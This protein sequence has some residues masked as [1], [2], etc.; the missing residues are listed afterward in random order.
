MLKRQDRLET[1]RLKNNKYK[2]DIETLIYDMKTR[3]QEDEE[4][5]AVTTATER[6]NIL[7]AFSMSIC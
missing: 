4:I 6:E 5:L 2:N 1:I 7:G 3:I